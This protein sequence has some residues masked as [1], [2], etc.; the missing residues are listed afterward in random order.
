MFRVWC[1]IRVVHHNSKL[2]CFGM[3][4]DAA[5]TQTVHSPHNVKQGKQTPKM[6][7]RD[8]VLSATW[9]WEHRQMADRSTLVLFLYV[10]NNPAWIQWSTRWFRVLFRFHQQGVYP[11]FARSRE[12]TSWPHFLSETAQKLR[13][14]DFVF[15]SRPK[16]KAEIET[17]QLAGC[18]I[19][20][21]AY[22]DREASF[23]WPFFQVTITFPRVLSNDQTVEDSIAVAIAN[24]VITMVDLKDDPVLATVNT[25]IVVL[26]MPQGTSNVL[27]S[28]VRSRP[29]HLSSWPTSGWRPDRWLVQQSIS[30]ESWVI[31]HLNNEE[32]GI[33]GRRHVLLQRWVKEVLLASLSNRASVALMSFIYS[34]PTLVLNLYKMQ[35]PDAAAKDAV[36]VML[37]Y[38]YSISN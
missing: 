35:V 5:A 1:E 12:I 24:V 32:Q 8:A 3:Q 38:C 21:A 4:I 15:Y 10:K 11:L 23:S 30:L 20:Y 29:T 16:L 7:A 2:W 6:K 28:V 13:I 26:F 9:F 34:S 22:R 17:A 18:I 27:Y 25:G 14:D 19:E 36:D 37:F 33:F 31:S